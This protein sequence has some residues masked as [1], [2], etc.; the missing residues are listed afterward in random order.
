[1]TLDTTQN[2][3]QWRSY[4]FGPY[5]RLAQAAFPLNDSEKH[6][7]SKTRIAFAISLIALALGGIPLLFRTIW[8]FVQ[9]STTTVCQSGSLLK[10]LFK[11]TIFLVILYELGV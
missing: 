9:L 7:T 5:F 3:I 2:Q 11:D 8:L 10:L 1:M 6:P 4:I